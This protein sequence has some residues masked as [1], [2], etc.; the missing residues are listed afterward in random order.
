MLDGGALAHARGQAYAVYK[1]FWRQYFFLPH[2]DTYCLTYFYLLIY[3]A[4][5]SQE[6]SNTDNR[7]DIGI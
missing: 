3:N 7:V 6:Y 5:E 4:Q 2:L 1:L